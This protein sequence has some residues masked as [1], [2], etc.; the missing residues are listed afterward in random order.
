MVLTLLGVDVS[1]FQGRPDWARVKA[2]GITFAFARVSFGTTKLDSSYQYNRRSIPAAGI[3]PGAYHF[4]TNTSSVVTQADTFCR[5]VD[6]NAMHALDVEFASLDVSGWVRRYRTHFPHK[7]LLVY[8]GRDLWSRA[9]GGN[10]S[11]IGPLWV[12]GYVPNAY[13]SG[14]GSLA[15]QWAKVGSNDGGVPFGGWSSWTFMQFT[16]TAQVPGISG[17]VDGDAFDGTLAQLRALAATVPATPPPPQPGVLEMDLYEGPDSRVWDIGSAGKR[18]VTHPAVVSAYVG[19]GGK[20][21]PISAA[22]LDSIP[23]VPTWVLSP[24]PPSATVDVVALAAALAP[25]LPPVVDP[26][27]VAHQV[28]IQL[29]AALPR[30]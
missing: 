22:G 13:V 4:L 23:T 2:A 11:R 8:T 12:A 6:P 1:E 24:T 16:D 18:Y 15:R 10:G 17:G 14:S 26:V 5:T 3:V 9:G 30:A 29:G 21:Q 28:L 25:H 20:V 19:K 7:T 27:A